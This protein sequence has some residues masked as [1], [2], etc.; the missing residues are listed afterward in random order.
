M[1]VFLGLTEVSGYYRGL[2]AGFRELGV[3]CTFI[4]LIGNPRDYRGH[5]DSPIVRVIRRLYARRQSMLGRARLWRALIGALETILRIVVFT[6]VLLTHDVF[7]FGFN[8]TFL[9]YLEL[10]VL[11][12]LGKRIIYQYHGSD[13]RPP[14]LNG[15]VVQSVDD[16]AIRACIRETAQK[17]R[18]LKTIERHAHFI[19]DTPTQGLLHERPF[20]QWLRIGVAS[21]PPHIDQQLKPQSE[22]DG[23]RVLHCPSKPH[24]KGT[25]EIRRIVEQLRADGCNLE[26]VE[27]TG[28]S[29]DDV[30]E[31][32]ADC[33]IVVDQMYADYAM[34]SFAT[35]AAWFG[36]PILIGGYAVKLWEELLPPEWRPP[37]V[38]CL[39]EDMASNLRR[40]IDDRSHREE[41][42]RRCRQFVE[43]RWSPK[44]IAARYVRL[45]EGDIPDDWWCDPADI[46]YVEG[47]C[48]AR[49]RVA[50][51]LDRVLALG[52]DSALAVDDKP[53]LLSLLKSLAATA[54]V[55]ESPNVEP[56][57]PACTVV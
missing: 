56:S 41:V 16:E 24:A 11:R 36:K 37:T 47:C 32:I 53:E 2:K 44:D 25:D 48:L 54:E 50:Q 31:A 3:K 55:A 42:G 30:M 35:E 12:L 5:D 46:R 39:P 21:R 8:T 7:I 9:R 4:D 34:P 6:R 51:I 43:R 33:D 38:Y 13:S 22:R 57:A 14:Y 27:I 19:I 17:K 1:R 15:S 28:R 29:N 10:P 18:Q 49:Q 26:Y 52:G 45:V 23:V 20:I 40:L